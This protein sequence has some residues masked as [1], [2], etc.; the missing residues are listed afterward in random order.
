MPFQTARFGQKWS[1]IE[2]MP[3]VH[4]QIRKPTFRPIAA[5]QNDPFVGFLGFGISKQMQLVGA[6]FV[7]S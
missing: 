3:K 1:F 2:I 5:A 7:A 6:D 4:L